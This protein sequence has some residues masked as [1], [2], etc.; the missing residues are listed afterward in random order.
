[1]ASI[2]DIMA[3]RNISASVQKVETG[4][5]NR[6][7][8]QFMT[9][10]EDV[11]GD[12]TTYLTFYGQRQTARRVE[13]GAPSRSRTLRPSGEQ[14]VTLV[15]FSEHVK[16]RQELWLQLRE[17]NSLMAQKKAQEEI[18]RAGRDHRQL[19]DNTRIASIISM[20]ANG[21][22][23]FDAG[24]NILP[25]AASSALTVDYAIP[26]NN[27]NQLNGIIGTSWANVAAPIVQNIE[28]IKIQMMKNTG[29]EPAHA[30]YGSNIA[31]YLY[32]NNTVGKYWQYNSA[33]YGQFQA[34]PGVI[35][36]GTFGIANW[37]R[38]GDS[39]FASNT[40]S[41]SETINMQ[42]DGDLLTITPEITPNTYTLYEGSIPVPTRLGVENSAE[43]ALAAVE[44]V[45]GIGGYAVLEADP[46]GIKSVYFDTFLNHWKTPAD[47][48]QA[49]VAF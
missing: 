20:L 27:R 39:F 7:P 48:F 49:D 35:P 14:S 44:I 5:P 30:F 42:W 31:N 45:Y 1:M 40:N 12:R 6:L 37:H 34:T 19:F 43:A 46:V 9:V 38:M 8:S 25:S 41:E 16:L 33:L 24:G 28:D 2:Q 23:W 17:A 29:R 18:A 15:H 22:V 47:M 21:K 11:L 4:I 13:Y 26:A 32:T 10:K 36:N 3:W